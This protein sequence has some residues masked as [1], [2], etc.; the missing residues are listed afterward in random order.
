[1]PAKG[2]YS[3]DDHLHISRPLEELNPILSRWM[4]AEDINVA[5]LLQFGT[6]R[7]FT[8]A[9]QYKHGPDGVYSEGHYLLVSGQENPRNRFLGHG[10]ILGARTPIHFP[11]EYLI[12]RKFWKEARKQGGL[13]GYAHWGTGSEAQTGLALDLPTGLLDFL[14]VLECWDANYDVWYEIL[15][16]GIRMT[17]TGGTDYGTLP[18]LPGRERFYTEVKGPLTVKSWLD[19]LRRGATFVTNGP[20]LEF[21]IDD[22]GMGEEVVLPRPGTVR[23]QARMRFDPERDDMFRIEVVRNGI[24]WKSFPRMGPSSEISCDIK[25]KVEETCWLAVRAWG[26]KLGEHKPPGGYVPP[27]RNRNRDA[28]ASL[29]HSAAIYVRVEGT[30]D[31][32]TQDR[33]KANARAWT[34]RLDELEMKLR[35][36]NLHFLAVENDKYDPDMAYLLK[37]RN[38][39]QGA[40]QMAREYYLKFFR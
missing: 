37:S 18:N 24:V 33:A 11:E 10:I 5:N 7:S 26:K 40:I 16:S 29:A 4:Q 38:A 14:E 35:D 31:L 30:R 28:P 20:M 23:L 27:W 9:P 39:L 6:F 12:F 25:L 1:M 13:S 17:P 36:E 19:G 21:Q 2:W 34:A 22:K 32:F 15:N 3:A 8:A